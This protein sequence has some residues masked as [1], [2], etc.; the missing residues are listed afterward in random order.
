MLNSLPK[1]G[2][3]ENECLTYSRKRVY[4][5]QPA[6]S[7]WASYSQKGKVKKLHTKN[8]LT[9]TLSYP[10]VP[11]H[12]HLQVPAILPARTAERT[13]STRVPLPPLAAQS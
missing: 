7:A 8:Y 11:T 10:A 9:H 12:A 4:S 13:P 2:E 5:L 6:I 3:R 1:N